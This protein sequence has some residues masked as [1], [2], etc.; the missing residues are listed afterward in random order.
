MNRTKRLFSLLMTGVL[1]SALAVPAFADNGKSN[2]GKDR[3]FQLTQE[4]VTG[5]P[6]FVLRKMELKGF[7]FMEKMQI[8]AKHREL[9]FDVPPVIKDGRTLIPVRAIT[10]AMG[11]TVDYDA[12]EGIVTVTSADEEIVI[13]FYLNEE[14]EGKITVTKDG[15]T[16]DVTTDVRPGIINNRTFV[17]LRFIAETLGLKVTHD[18]KTGGIDID[19]GLKLDK[20][21]FTFAN[22]EVI[23]DVEITFSPKADY[24]LLRIENGDEELEDEDYSVSD[25]V[26]TLEEDYLESLTAEKTVLTLVFE[27]EEGE[28]VSRTVEIRI[29][30]EGEYEEPT[31]NKSG[32]KFFSEDEIEDTV[33]TVVWN[34]HTLKEI[35]EDGDKLTAG[36]DY[37]VSGDKITLKAGYLEDL[38][39]GETEL[40]LVFVAGDQ[41]EEL[42]FTVEK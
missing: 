28:E 31:I 12:E 37:S 42:T 21:R 36:T 33:I 6:E 11:A 7:T 14:D 35:N 16:E 26:I 1:L 38:P 25:G 8:R 41:T 15:E 5:K 2:N 3:G 4:K 32:V 27:D 24:E 39:D 19:E 23:D 20:A 29:D 34:G 22:R 10:E 9:K 18:G 40:T 30:Q 13:K 17:P